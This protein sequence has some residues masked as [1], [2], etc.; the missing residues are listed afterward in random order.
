MEALKEAVNR[1]WP[2]WSYMFITWFS[3]QFTHGEQAL[4]WARDHSDPIGTPEITQATSEKSWDDLSRINAQ[5]QVALVSLCRD[6]ALTIVRN[7][8][9]GHGLDAW[10]RMCKEYEPT[11]DQANLRLLKRVLQPAQQSIDGLRTAM[12][13]W[14][15]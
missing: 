1:E 13:T 7:S 8:A 15:R 9:K 4:E 6:E 5:L 14:V 10:R 3:S 2:S 12:E 11:T